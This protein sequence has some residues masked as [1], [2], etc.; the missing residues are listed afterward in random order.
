MILIIG[1]TYQGKLKYA[2]CK[3]QLSDNDIFTCIS[4]QPTIDFSCRCIN[5]LEEFTYACTLYGVDALDYFQS[6]RNRWANSVLIC[7]DMFCGVV[8]LG[9]EMRAWR[10]NTGRLCQYLAGEADQVIR[11]FCGL[12]QQLK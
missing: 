9:E 4:E 3:F 10:Q 1:G 8:P 5:R 7:Q 12:E 6:H 2:A 11:I